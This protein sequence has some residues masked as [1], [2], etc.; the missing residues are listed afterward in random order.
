MLRKEAEGGRFRSKIALRLRLCAPVW[1][2]TETALPNFDHR[3]LSQIVF[4][5][6]F[7]IAATVD[8]E[9]ALSAVTIGED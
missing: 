9:W 8:R 1:T 7:R 6:F 4:R 2:A 3:I 5:L